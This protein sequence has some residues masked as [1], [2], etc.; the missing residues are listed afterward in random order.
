MSIHKK[1]VLVGIDFPI[2]CDCTDHGKDH[3]YV[4][5]NSQ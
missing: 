4:A 2:N 3:K 1:K 5:M